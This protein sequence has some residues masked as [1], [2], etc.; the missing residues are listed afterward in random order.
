MSI[1]GCL[2][3]PLATRSPK[4]IRLLLITGVGRR[5]AMRSPPPLSDRIRGPQRCTQRRLPWPEPL[6]SR[7]RDRSASQ[8]LDGRLDTLNSSQDVIPHSHLDKP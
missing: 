3:V 6:L 5:L 1:S 4:K 8:R 7:R 2:Q